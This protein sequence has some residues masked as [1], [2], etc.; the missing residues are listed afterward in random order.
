MN[1]GFENIQQPLQQQVRILPMREVQHGTDEVFGERIAKMDAVSPA[2]VHSVATI[3]ND[4]FEL[5]L[6]DLSPLQAGAANQERVALPA[7]WA[8]GVSRQLKK[9]TAVRDQQVAP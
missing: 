5:G 3:S 4:R 1:S 9:G 6:M 8:V 2:E 7:A